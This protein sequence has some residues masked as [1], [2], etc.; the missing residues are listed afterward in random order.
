MSL[1]Q[2]KILS[3]LKSHSEECEQNLNEKLGTS[4]SY[5]IDWSVVPDDAAGWNWENDDLKVLFYNSFYLPFER[6]LSELFSDEFYKEEI[7]K[8]V[9]TIRLAPGRS[10]LADY[11]FSDG[12]MTSKHT[13]SVNQGGDGGSMMSSFVK[14]LKDTVEN[15]LE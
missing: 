15:S 3:V 12:V 5:D 6:G 10:M 13:M 8:Q 2:R 4:F 14:N 11:E 7:M 1:K 9:K